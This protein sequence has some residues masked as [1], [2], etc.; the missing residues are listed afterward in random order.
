M[1]YKFTYQHRVTR[2]RRRV[3]KF[4]YQHRVTKQQGRC[5]TRKD[6]KDDKLNTKTKINT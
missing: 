3:Y 2:Q 1:L 4:T 6:G 5:L